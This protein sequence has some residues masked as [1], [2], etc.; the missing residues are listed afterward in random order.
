MAA[1]EWQALH[2]QH[3]TI[4]KP[5]FLWYQMSESLYKKKFNHIFIIVTLQI[6]DHFN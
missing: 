6:F 4:F 5:N 3:V 2:F 1:M